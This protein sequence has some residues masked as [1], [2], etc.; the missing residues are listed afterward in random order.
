MRLNLRS[1]SIKQGKGRWFESILAY[2]ILKIDSVSSHDG[3]CHYLNRWVL[4]FYFFS[5]RLHHWIGSDDN[6]YPHNHPWWF[7]SCVLKGRLIEILP[8]GSKAIRKV[9][10]IQFFPSQHLHCVKADNCWTLLI[11]GKQKYKWGFLVDDQI[12]PKKKY[13]KVFGHHQCE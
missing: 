9:G 8:N 3:E 5:I 6:R 7:I 2:R 13:F 12:I 4:D 10:S 11:T 1:Q